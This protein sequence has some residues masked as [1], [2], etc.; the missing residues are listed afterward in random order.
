M[1]THHSLLQKGWNHFESLKSCNPVLALF[2]LFFV[3]VLHKSL[4]VYLWNWDWGSRGNNVGEEHIL[5]A[6]VCG[7]GQKRALI[8]IC[9][10]IVLWITPLQYPRWVI[11]SPYYLNLPVLNGP[12]HFRDHV[13]YC[14]WNWVARR[15]SNG[16]HTCTQKRSRGDLICH[17]CGSDFILP[18]LRKTRNSN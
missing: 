10:D 7:L 9:E 6:Q 11:W 3:I 2:L 8:K 15:T 5:Y 17:S 12:T 14:L 13:I 4:C 18:P 1:H 16:F